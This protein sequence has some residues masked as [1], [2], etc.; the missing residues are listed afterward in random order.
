M[1][2]DSRLEKAGY[3]NGIKAPADQRN[4]LVQK[5]LGLSIRVPGEDAD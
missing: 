1:L 5:L 2:P 4:C 3:L